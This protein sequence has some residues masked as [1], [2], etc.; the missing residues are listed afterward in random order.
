MGKPGRVLSVPC[1]TC[2]ALTRQPCKSRRGIAVHQARWEALAELDAQGRHMWGKFTEEEIEA[3]RSP[4]G[5]FTEEQL[6]AWGVP[7][8]PP[9]GWR[10]RLVYGDGPR[11]REDDGPQVVVMGH[12]GAENV[13]PETAEF[14]PPW[15]HP[16]VPGCLAESGITVSGLVWCAVH[17][18]YEELRDGIPAVRAA[19]WQ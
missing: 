15:E 11:P 2:Y 10:H 4:A 1:P 17:K 12:T 7:W 5:G 6:A 18:E 14:W 8:P 9:R 19:G 13:I 3:G 16:P